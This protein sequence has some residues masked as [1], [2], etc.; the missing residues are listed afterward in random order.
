MIIF[1]F[2]FLIYFLDAKVFLTNATIHSLDYSFTSNCLLHGNES[3]SRHSSHSIQMY[4]D[5]RIKFT[6]SIGQ[7]IPLNCGSCILINLE[8]EYD[9]IYLNQNLT[10]EHKNNRI[11]YNQF[12]GIIIDIIPDFD[13]FL[14]NTYLETNPIQNNYLINYI[15]YPCPFIYDEFNEFLFC[16]TIPCHDSNYYFDKSK[17]K[18][19]YDKYYFTIHPRN[20][21]YNIILIKLY[22]DN[23]LF[24][25]LQVSNDNG[26]LMPVEFKYDKF[27]LEC[28]DSNGHSFNYLFSFNEIM[29]S[30]INLHYHGGIILYKKLF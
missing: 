25:Y 1:F 28:T 11:I 15:E 27:Y 14:L 7:N 6:I 16:S 17:F 10:K 24:E 2:N 30:Q 9:R 22:Y 29:N 3:Y 20:F 23:H 19:Y 5:A 4:K 8:N 21:K 13:I 12:I 18:Y 26:Y